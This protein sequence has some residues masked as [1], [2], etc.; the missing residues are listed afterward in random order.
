MN[1]VLLRSGSVP[2][3]SPALPGSPKVHLSRHDTGVFS[4]ERNSGSSKNSLHLETNGRKDRVLIR[5]AMSEETDVFQPESTGRSRCSKSAIPEE[6]HVADVEVD[7]F[8]SLKRKA[9]DWPSYAPI[10]PDNRIPIEEFGFSGNGI[11]RSGND[12]G[13]PGDGCGDGRFGDRSKIGNYY[14]EMLKLNPG[15]SLLLRNYGKYLH[16]V[17]NNVE[18]AEEYYGR[19][20]LASPGDGEVLSLYGKLIWETQKDEDRAKAYFDRAVFASPDDCMVLGSYAHFMWEAEEE[21]EE[22]EEAEVSQT[23]VAAF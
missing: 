2:V 7:D 22:E 12:Q 19:A 5:R 21:E 4:G 18:K 8:L 14:R 15:D 16:E 11:G 23:K 17:E 1:F 20:I 9:G 10:R 13:K 3:R 6:E